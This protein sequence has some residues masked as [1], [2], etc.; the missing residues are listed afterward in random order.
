MRF[1]GYILVFFIFLPG[2][3]SFSQD[4]LRN[5]FWNDGT[6]CSNPARRLELDVFQLSGYGISNKVSIYLHPLMVWLLPQVKVKAGWGEKKG[7]VFATE[8][9]VIYPTFFLSVVSRK[10][11]GGLVSPEYHY[12]QMFSFNNAFL[13]SYSPFRKALL[14]AKAGVI[15]AIKFGPLD[16]N[17]TIDLP[18]IY[19]MLA[20]FYN[21]P[22]INPGIDFRG[23]FHRLFG[24]QINAE[25]FI[26]TIKE[27][28]FFFQNKGVIAY[29]SKKNK[30]KLEAG[31]KLCYGE[32]PFGTQWNLLPSLDFAFG[33]NAGKK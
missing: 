29:Y 16:P 32:Y 33:I 13:V 25:C 11:T 22:E 27:N 10:G 4:S 3:Q 6:A 18:V 9:E 14:T 1:V 26:L 21:N 31:Y 23:R 24:W 7:F 28:N 15:F 17:S 5:A 8:H 2:K 30:F 12:P 20:P 19:P